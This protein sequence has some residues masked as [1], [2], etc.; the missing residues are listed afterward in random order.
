MIDTP[1]QPINAVQ[2]ARAAGGA[3][4]RFVTWSIPSRIQDHIR[5]NAYFP[6]VEVIGHELMVGATSRLL[7]MMTGGRLCEALEDGRPG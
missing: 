3:R 7:P 5:G 2:L 1:Q 4:R 6:G